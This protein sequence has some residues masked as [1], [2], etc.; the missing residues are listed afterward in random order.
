MAT[1]TAG[2]IIKTHQESMVIPMDKDSQIIVTPEKIKPFLKRADAEQT[3]VL[4]RLSHHVIR[5][6]APAEKTTGQAQVLEL[7]EEGNNR[8]RMLIIQA[9]FHMVRRSKMQDTFPIL[10]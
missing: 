3:D 10:K 9:A 4:Y 5:G 7:L 6:C 1:D 2:A 8:Q